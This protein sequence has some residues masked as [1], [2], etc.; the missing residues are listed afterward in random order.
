[1]TKQEKINQVEKVYQ[2]EYDSLVNC[3]NFILNNKEDAQ[4]AVQDGIKNAI[5][6]INKYI[7]NK[8]IKSWC[9]SCVVNAAK[10]MYRKKKQI[11]LH[12]PLESLP[13]L[14]FNE[15]NIDIYDDEFMNV[16]ENM[17]ENERVALMLWAN[18]TKRREIAEILDI[19]QGTV[20]STY[21][22]ALKKIKNKTA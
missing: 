11:P 2:S 4:D 22:R 17:T 9:Y 15:L 1:M 12:V 18:G 21:Y 14:K 19:P 16:C 6:R 20:A 5:S 3:A 13:E 10:D 8:N 7:Y